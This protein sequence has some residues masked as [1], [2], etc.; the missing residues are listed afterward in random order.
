MDAILAASPDVVLHVTVAVVAGADVH[1]GG[2]Y[3]LDVFLLS[4]EA[5]GKIGGGHDG[6]LVCDAQTWR[7]QRS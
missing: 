7:E 5:G 1:L 3:L 2:K 6:Y 4:L